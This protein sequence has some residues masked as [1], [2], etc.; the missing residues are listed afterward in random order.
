MTLVVP[1]LLTLGIAVCGASL[2][3]LVA[4][5][6]AIAVRSARPPAPSDYRPPI[7]VLKPICGL[8]PGLY[9]NLHS[10]CDQDYPVFQVLFG[11]RDAEDPAVHIVER[12]MRECPGRDLGLVVDSRIIG[13]NYKISNLANMFGA[14][15]YDIVLVAD[16]DARVDE[17]CLAAVAASFEDRAVGAVTCLYRGVPVGGAP[18][19][20][21]AMFINDWLAPSVMVGLSFQK[22][23]FCLGALM[24]VRR[25]ALE[26]IGGLD[27]LASYLA[28]DF[29][30]GHLVARRGFAVA[31]S[32]YVVENRVHES[33]YRQMV[34]HELR[35]ARTMR[36]VRPAGYF[37]SFLTDALPLAA[38]ITA[39]AA[40]LEMGFRLPERPFDFDAVGLGI[41]L[42]ALVLRIRLHYAVRPVLGIE[43]PAAPWLVPVRDLISFG[44]RV[45]S[46]IGRGVSWR[47]HKFA[48]RPDGTLHARP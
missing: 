17:D 7:T 31:L 10:F 11:V 43:G 5:L 47:G 21:G 32:S 40:L 44:I 38:L 16:S 28:D 26:A 18:S 33:S 15:K 4:A 27:A 42:A 6:G 3:Y 12:L 34:E 30:L 2:V 45:A 9:E 8:E 14:A 20:L 36:T 22:L 19:M 39:V 48:V 24:A 25:H 41:A 35:W 23:S 29:M 13:T 46:F 37:L 1:F